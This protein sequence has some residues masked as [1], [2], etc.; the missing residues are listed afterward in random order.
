MESPSFSSNPSK[1]TSKMQYNS[2]Q[3][4]QEDVAKDPSKCIVVFNNKVY[5]LSKW[6]RFHPGGE[7][8]VRHMNGR[9]ATDVIL[10]YHPDWVLTKKLPHFCIGELPSPAKASSSKD[11]PSLNNSTSRISVAYRQLDARLRQEGL[12]DTDYGFYLR[13]A[14]KFLVLWVGVI[15]VA[16]V[17]GRSETY[18][19]YACVGSALMAALLW[20]QGAF[21]AHDAGHSAITHDAHTDTLLGISLANFMGGLSLGWWKQNHN[22][23]HIVTNHPEHDPDIQHLPFFAVTT[24]FMKNLTST[25]YK[26]LMP[27]DA[28]AKV[29]V[30]LQH[31]LFYIVLAFGRFNL[32]ANSWAHLLNFKH[33]VPHRS[34]EIFGLVFFIAWYSSLLFLCFPLAS[35]RIT[36]L[37]VS[38]CLTV[39][40]H[41]QITLSHFGMDTDPNP[42]PTETYAELAI[43]TTMDVDC[44]RWMDWVHGGLQFQVAHHMYPRIPRHNL[45]KVSAYVKMFAEEQGLEYHLYK[46]GEGNGVVL[47][48]L[49]SVAREVK[50]VLKGGKEGVVETANVV[51]GMQ[52]KTGKKE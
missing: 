17:W 51:R 31:Y 41:V 21:V 26:R 50:K 38:H 48:L 46:F 23:H 44:P 22:V 47:R 9:D 35:Q 39:L 33:P 34:L 45:R 16:A 43:R 28:F 30:P 7:L 24:L 4:I 3:Q 32:Y 15:Y 36:H 8:A 52:M 25:Y 6:A 20:H 37:L 40:L 13:E 1:L 42:L 5:D 18:G 27:F 10:A 14:L 29:F 12:Y 2:L 11:H 49:G 19:W